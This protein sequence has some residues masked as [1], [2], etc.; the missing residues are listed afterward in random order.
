MPKPE[1]EFP[2]IEDGRDVLQ[3]LVDK[4]FGQLPMQVVI[5][6]SSTLAVLAKDAGHTKSKPAIMIEMFARDG[7]ELGVLIASVDTL[8]GGGV[9]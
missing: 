2:T 8:S 4:G 1:N 6:P 7:V 9:H 3:Q 5:V